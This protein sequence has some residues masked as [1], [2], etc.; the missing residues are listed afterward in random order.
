MANMP[1]KEN[2]LVERAIAWIR[3]VVPPN[4]SV[5]LSTTAYGGGNPTEPQ[6]LADRGIDLVADNNLRT[7]VLVEAKR[8]FTP[9][10][11]ELTFGV[12][13][14]RLLR[15]MSYNVPILVVSEWLSS[16]TRELLEA[17][18]INYLDLTGNAL[19]RLASPVVYIRAQGQARAPKRAT[20]GQVG[21]RG[22][23]AAHIVRLLLDAC[24]PYGVRDI[25][26]ASGVAQSW[27]SR[28]L[29]ALDREAL[30]DRAPRG[31]VESVDVPRLVRRWAD[32]YDLFTTNKATSFLAPSGATQVLARM[33][34]APAAGR[35]VVTG[36]FATVRLAPVAAPT[37]LVAYSGDVD[38][39]STALGLLP[40]SEGANVVLL[41]PYDPVVWDRTVSDDGVEFASPSQVAVDCLTGNGRMP[42]EGA[43]LLDWMVN[44]EP[45]WRTPSLTG[46]RMTATA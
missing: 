12:N 39:A 26:A 41:T 2:E 23:K 11:V 34:R 15:T 33:K 3:Q 19:I 17:Q 25:A 6:T 18:G 40:A 35:L 7:T 20:K 44:N 24:P 31:R 27:V 4:W 5:Q 43:A 37:L 45:A 1:F 46:A 13:L 8:E 16:R 22:P 28:L 21:L 32:D 14:A 36:S 29:E 10:D 42:A 38:R 9:R 30:I